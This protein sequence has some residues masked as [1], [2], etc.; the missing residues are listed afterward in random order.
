MKTKNLLSAAIMTI[1]VLFLTTSAFSYPT[2]VTGRTKKTSTTGC[3][4]HTQNTSIAGWITGPDTV[5]AGTSATF[6]VNLSR[7][8]YTGAHGGTDIAVR[9]G[10]LAVLDNRLHLSSGELTQSAALTYSGG[11][12]AVTFT[13]TAPSSAGIDTIWCNAVAGYSN[14]WNWGT[15]KRIIVTNPTG[16]TN[17]QTP[18]Q[19]A[20]YQNYPNPFNPST[21]ISFD[22][23]KTS[24]VSLTIYDIAGKIVDEMNGTYAQGNHNYVWNAADMSSG[25]YYYVLKSNDFISTK[26]MILVK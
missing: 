2:G 17:N 1:L 6:T 19:F 15:E 5:V 18:V 20:L 11:T 8:G 7:S 21:T 12:V 3:S 23:P 13:Y 16:I 14:G 4:C 9:L 26:K 10:A 24:A 22:V 25:V